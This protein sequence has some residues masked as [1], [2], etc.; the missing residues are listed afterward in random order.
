MLWYF[1]SN[2]FQ[3]RACVLLFSKKKQCIYYK[4]NSSIYFYVWGCV[5]NFTRPPSTSRLSSRLELTS[6]VHNVCKLSSYKK[7][8][9]Q[10]ALS[11]KYRNLEVF[12]KHLVFFCW[13]M[14]VVKMFSL[15]GMSVL[16]PHTAQQF[17][18][19][20]SPPQTL[21]AVSLTLITL[22]NQTQS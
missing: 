6:W 20:V 12:I 3:N 14:V 2:T 4:H 22:K 7:M 13:A 17:T 18:W 9:L 8:F 11:W 21:L 15:C 1:I 5:S 10:H 19:W 16:C